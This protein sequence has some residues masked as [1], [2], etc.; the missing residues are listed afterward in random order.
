MV[1]RPSGKSSTAQWVADRLGF[2][3]VDSGSLYRAV[4]AAALAADPAPEAWTRDRRADP[5]R[6]AVTLEPAGGGSFLP[7]IDG[8]AV[9]DEIRGAEVTRAVSLVAQMPRRAGLGERAGAE[10][11][12]GPRRGGGRSG[13]GDRGVPRGATQGVSGG[14]PVGAGPPAAGAAAGAFARPT[15]RWPRRPT[16]WCSATRRTRRRPCRRATP[17]WSTRPTSRRKSRWSGSWR[18]PGP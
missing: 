7:L 17:W 5:R 3:H 10:C 16:G 1:R 2:R 13:H 8:R 11:G 4:T 15:P 18:W 9:G 6:R 12:P 14:R